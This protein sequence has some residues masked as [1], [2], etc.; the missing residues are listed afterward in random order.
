M[1]ENLSGFMQFW[2][3]GAIKLTNEIARVGVQEASGSNH[4]GRT[5]CWARSPSDGIQFEGSSNSLHAFWRDDLD[6]IDLL[7][8][9]F[10]LFINQMH[11]LPNSLWLVLLAWSS[12]LFKKQSSSTPI[13]MEQ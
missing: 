11:R 6:F 8:Y 3:S 4:W 12:H 9:I 7:I 1:T 5:R 10:Y 13:T 2:H